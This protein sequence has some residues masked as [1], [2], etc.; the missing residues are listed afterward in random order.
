MGHLSRYFFEVARS[1][2]RPG[3]LA[4]VAACRAAAGRDLVI[5]IAGEKPWGSDR[6]ATPA[7]ICGELAGIICGELAGIVG[8]LPAY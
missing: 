2:S 4:R 1:S 6:T 7:I 8:D 3:F 5:A